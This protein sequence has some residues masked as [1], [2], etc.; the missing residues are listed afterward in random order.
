MVQ[1]HYVDVEDFT[2][3]APLAGHPVLDFCNTRAGWN[4]A[5]E[6]E[7]LQRYDHLAAWTAFAGLLAPERVRELR[8][9][10][11][12]HEAAAA[13]ALQ[14]ARQARRRVYRALLDPGSPE[15]VE[16]CAA[17]VRTAMARMG[18]SVVGGTPQWRVDEEAGLTA[19]LVAVMWSAAQL[20]TAPEAR[21]VRACP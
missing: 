12:R 15:A 3:P 16:A 10:A 5:P 11:R 20:L 14:H 2:L 17:D 8:A 6:N 9:H 7:Y 13:A 1:K 4:G 21:L 18:L 19:P